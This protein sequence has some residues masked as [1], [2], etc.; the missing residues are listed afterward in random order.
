MAE[1]TSKTSYPHDEGLGFVDLIVILIK[2]R[3]LWIGI[4]LVGAAIGLGLLL[5][6]KYLPS[7]VSTIYSASVKALVVDPIIQTAGPGDKIFAS[8]NIAAAIA[9]SG[10]AAD[11]V[12]KA[13]GGDAAE[14]YRKSA[15]AKFDEKTA[16]LEIDVISSSAKSAAELAAAG[17]EATQ[18]IFREVA[19]RHFIPSE[20][21][22]PSGY[23]QQAP[24]RPDVQ[25][26]PEFKVIDSKVTTMTNSSVFY[27]AKG[28]VLI[29]FI[30]LFIGIIS[31]FV[32]NGCD[33]VRDDPEAMA[34]LRAAKGRG[35]DKRGD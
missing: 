7:N 23:Q 26:L 25:A 14:Q 3:R 10:A 29:C 32:A 13:N 15:T 35:S 6:G 9:T 12:G 16:V 33:R 31:A 17:A 27:T 22:A 19:S 24:A 34:K 18:S 8:G 2:K 1:A 30:S 11:L 20:A 5:G 28:L 4:T 21:K